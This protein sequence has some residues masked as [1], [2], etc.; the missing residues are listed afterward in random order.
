MSIRTFGLLTQYG[1]QASLLLTTPHF[2]HIIFQPFQQLK[3]SVLNRPSQQVRRELALGEQF[4]GFSRLGQSTG[5]SQ[6]TPGILPSSGGIG[7]AERADHFKSGGW[8]GIRTHDTL[9]TYTHF[10]GARLRPLGHP[11][12]GRAFLI[13]IPSPKPDST[14]M[15]CVPCPCPAHRPGLFCAWV[16]LC[17]IGPPLAAA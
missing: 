6:K 17:W 7:R 3:T 4:S 10:P 9:L 15:R 2:R 11:S 1:S 5:L 16:T 14:F 13:S 8:G 12:C